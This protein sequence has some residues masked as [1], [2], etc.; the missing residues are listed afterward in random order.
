MRHATAFVLTTL[1]AG[2]APAT[3][4]AQDPPATDNAK[5]TDDGTSKGSKFRDPK[6]GQLDISQF[7]AMPHRFLPVP[8][9]IT[10]PAVGYGGGMAGLFIRP[11]KDAGDEGYARPNMSVA[12]AFGTENDTWGAFA[13]DASRWID[14]RLESLLAGATGDVNLDFYGLAS[15]DTPVRYSLEFSLA[16]LQGNWHFSKDSPWSAGLRYIYAQIDSKLRD[17]PNRPGL[18]DDAEYTVSAPAVVVEY[19]SRNNL[20]TPTKGWYAESVFL[21]STEDLGAS[22]D[23]ERFQQVLMTWYPI[24]EKFTLGARVDYQWASDDAPFFLRPYVKLRGVQAMRYQ[25]DE[26]ASAE[27]EVR[28]KFHDR[29]SAV[30]AGG[31]GTAKTK[32]GLFAGSQDVA[33]GAVGFRYELARLFG[34]HAGMDLAFSS[35]T[36]AIYIQIGNAWFRP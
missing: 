1:L 31:A 32:E 7:L 22:V 17:E 23:F 4:R 33:S 3:V 16:F 13:G 12:G 30:V 5:K 2:I 26:M 20:F 29:W 36:T 21:A 34:L 18:I 25:G 27:L 35:E 10:E 6:D 9:V 14:G 28:W 24:N 15:S 8:I 11:R 19:D